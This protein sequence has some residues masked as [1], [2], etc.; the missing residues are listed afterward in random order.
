MSARTFTIKAVVLLGLFAWVAPELLWHTRLFRESWSSARAVYAA[1]RKS[2]D[3]VNPSS[4]I[5]LGDSVANQFF[6]VH[7]DPP[8]YHSLTCNQAISMAGVFALLDRLSTANRLDGGKAL[9][10]FRPDSLSNDLDQPYTFQ[11]FV[12]PFYFGL[13]P[14]GFSPTVRARVEAIP[15]FWMAWV[16]AVR[17]SMWSPAMATV[18]SPTRRPLV[19]SPISVEY[20]KRLQDLA[21]ARRVSLRFRAPPLPAS[22]RSRDLSKVRE[23]VASAGLETLF[24]GYFDHLNYLPDDLFSDGVHLKSP[25]EVGTAFLSE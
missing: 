14:A 6:P 17:I 25:R 2:G 8:G 1:V 24:E 15:M 23:Q 11:Y 19:L 10:L 9:L 20:L 21:A 18:P 4:T 3:P 12:I 5:V 22:E 13:G 7:Q 16:P